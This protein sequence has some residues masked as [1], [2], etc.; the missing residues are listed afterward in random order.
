MIRFFGQ[1]LCKYPV[2]G[3]DKGLKLEATEVCRVKSMY[4]VQAVNYAK[5][6]QRHAKSV[7]NLFA[8]SF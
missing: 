3:L 7:R 4:K 2:Y 5:C 1:I 6:Q 8:H